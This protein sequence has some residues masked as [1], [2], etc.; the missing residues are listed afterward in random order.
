MG[1]RGHRYIVVVL[2]LAQKAQPYKQGVPNRDRI[3]SINT[4]MI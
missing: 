1:F 3:V 2:A 4:L